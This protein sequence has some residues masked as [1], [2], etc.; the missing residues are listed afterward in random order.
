MV[1][2]KRQCG[3]DLRW[4][5]YKPVKAGKTCAFNYAMHDVKAQ[6]L[7]ALIVLSS[8][9]KVENKSVTN[10]SMRLSKQVFVKKLY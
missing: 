10:V 8:S 7:S 3:P 1:R 4:N 2:A 5:L 9:G 6:A